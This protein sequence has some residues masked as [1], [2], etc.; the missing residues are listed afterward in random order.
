M[1]RYLQIIALFVMA[2]GVF[3]IGI[4]VGSHNTSEKVDKLFFESFISLV[5]TDVKG[6]VE[7]LEL[8]KD[9]NCTKAQE[10]IE[11]YLDIGLA[12][13]AVYVNK[14]PLKPDNNVIEAIS[15]AKKYREKY[16]GH[17]VNNVIK[18]SVTKTLDY[19][20]TK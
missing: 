16:P 9:G 11:S 10:R 15:L 13:I 12:D 20:K 4:K 6:K 17:R 7:L 8:I 5:A 3:L 14:K 19:V 18:N 1:K 2:I